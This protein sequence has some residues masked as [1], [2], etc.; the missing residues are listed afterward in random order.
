MRINRSLLTTASS[1]VLMGTAGAADLPVKARA[2]PAEVVAWNWTGPYVGFNLG[3]AQNHAEFTDLGSAG[4]PF[5]FAGLIGVPF[6]SPQE[7]VFTFGGQA[8]YNWQAGQFVFGVEGDWNWVDG[9]VN[10]ILTP[11]IGAVAASTNLEWTASL[12]GRVGLAFSRL[13]IYGTGGVSVAR[14][15]DAFGFVAFGTNAFSL[16]ETRTG[17]IGGGGLEYMV[18]RNVTARIEGLYADYGTSTI[19]V[20]NPPGQ[21]GPYG[22]SF[23]HAVSTVRAALNWKW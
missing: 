2:T 21:V 20:V 6:W 22:A 3:A 13:L 7:T 11:V 8:G 4:L 15:S 17:W 10:T 23:R 1:I 16:D 9:K 12:R 5:A 14:F 19:T 18:T